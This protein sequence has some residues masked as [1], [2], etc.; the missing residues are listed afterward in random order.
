MKNS[1]HFRSDQLKS[2][3]LC[4][5][6]CVLVVFILGCINMRTD[7]KKAETERMLTIIE[8]SGN[9][10]GNPDQG[11][12]TKVD[13]KTGQEVN[14]NRQTLRPS[15]HEKTITQVVGASALKKPSAHSLSEKPSDS[16][17]ANK[18][19]N[20]TDSSGSEL[21]SGAILSHRILTAPATLIGTQQ[22][23][24]V[25]AVHITVDAE[26]YVTEATAVSKGSTITDRVLWSKAQ[27]A[28]LQARFDK[29]RDGKAEQHGVYY[30]RFSFM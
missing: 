17:S 9:Y 18:K 14:R 19:T 27:Q 24:G 3:G 23:E 26:G 12:E 13:V 21:P 20:S 6:C 30:F 11:P 2:L 16:S 7:K 1:E 8:E 5:V 4:L 15:A 10:S 29:R 28:A 22:E 25:V